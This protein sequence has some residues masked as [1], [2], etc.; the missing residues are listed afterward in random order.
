MGTT[1]GCVWCGAAE[2][3]VVSRAGER[4][5]RTGKVPKVVTLP[6]GRGPGSAA[7]LSHLDRE[8]PQD[9]KVQ[10]HHTDKV[11]PGRVRR[12]ATD[13]GCPGQ[14]QLPRALLLR[15]PGSSALRGRA[16][17]LWVPA[18]RFR[19]WV[20]ALEQPQARA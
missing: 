5:E 11:E 6:R 2:G 14:S 8:K 16:P 9:A 20:A 4:G 12:W 15:Q 13:A 10:G 3:G 1:A 18:T 19:T 7:L 17:A